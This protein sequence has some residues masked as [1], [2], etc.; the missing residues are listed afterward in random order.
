[1]HDKTGKESIFV[2]EKADS[3]SS[4]SELFS[5]LLQVMAM[6]RSENGCVWDREQT[7]ETI[8]RNLVEEAYEAVYSIEEKDYQELKEEL[9]DIMLQVVFHSR[10]AEDNGVFKIEDVLRAIIKKLIRRHPH[11]FS[12]KVVRSSREVLSNWEDI[13]RQERQDKVCNKATEKQERSSM[14]S[15]I[16]IILPALYFAYEIQSRAARL[17]FDWEGTEGVIEKIKEETVELEKEL[18]SRNTN[19]ISDEIGDML[20]TIV[21]LSRHTGIDCE[22]SLK[23]TCKRFISRFNFMEKYAEEKGLDFR[24]LSLAEKDSLWEIAKNKAMT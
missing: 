4:P 13:K 22:K 7:H 19:K 14:F 18:N 9:G 2:V 17:G 3:I 8:K 24:S 21:N 16:P 6:L 15:N 12:G 11:V 23:D 10:I 5:M 20:F 1:M